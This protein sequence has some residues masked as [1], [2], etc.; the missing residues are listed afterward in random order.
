[1]SNDV[2]SM[3]CA[4]RTVKFLTGLLSCQLQSLQKEAFLWTP[5]HNY[6]RNYRHYIIRICYYVI[7]N[8]VT[9][10]FSVLSQFFPRWLAPNVLT[11]SGWLSLFMIYAVT[12]YYDPHFTAAGEK[13]KSKQ[14][15]S[16]WWLVFAVLHFAAHTLDGCDGK[17]ARRTSSR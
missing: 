7:I 4:H 6:D 14:I 5:L 17:Q 2:V 12:C 16:I 15:P 13:D 8:G 10:V 1:M 11:F 9:V 3:L